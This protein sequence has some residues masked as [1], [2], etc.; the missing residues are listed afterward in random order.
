MSLKMGW[1]EGEG[2][3][4]YFISIP[5]P[6]WILIYLLTSLLSYLSPF[7]MHSNPPSLQKL[8]NILSTV[9]HCPTSSQRPFP[10]LGIPK[11]YVASQIK[12]QGIFVYLFNSKFSKVTYFLTFIKRYSTNCDFNIT[13]QC[14]SISDLSVVLLSSNHV[15]GWF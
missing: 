7:Y 14:Y 4:D 13:D 5:P 3:V 12:F 6:W 11:E 2:G 8:V 10:L 15:H 1:G 9:P